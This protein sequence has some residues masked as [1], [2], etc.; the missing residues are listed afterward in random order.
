MCRRVAGEKLEKC[1]G[2][3]GAACLD[4]LGERLCVVEAALDRAVRKIASTPACLQANI[5]VDCAW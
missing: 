4:L 5:A 2:E 1:I 3:M